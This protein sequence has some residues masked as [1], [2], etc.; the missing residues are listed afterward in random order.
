MMKKEMICLAIFLTAL[1][2]DSSFAQDGGWKSH[3]NSMS[4]IEFKY[5]E[6]YVLEESRTPE[7]NFFGASLGLKNNKDTDWIID[8][9]YGEGRDWIKDGVANLPITTRSSTPNNELITV[10]ARLHCA[11]NGRACID[12]VLWTP[13]DTPNGLK[14]YEFYIKEVDGAKGPVFGVDISTNELLRVLYITPRKIDST[15][16]IE[17]IKGIVDS[18]RILK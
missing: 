12:F 10:V 13:F 2:S 4:G 18:I 8:I 3:I 7:G 1:F 14:A 5:P 9:P 17:D 11:S 6:K 15:E 16:I